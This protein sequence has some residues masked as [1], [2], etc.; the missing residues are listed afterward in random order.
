MFYIRLCPRYKG[1]WR[2]R[3]GGGG[4]GVQEGEEK[5]E[6]RHGSIVSFEVSRTSQFRRRESKKRRGV[7]TQA[8]AADR[9][10]IGFG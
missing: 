6:T 1:R 5:G 10:N 9:E 8:L 4:G 7:N 3:G 2:R